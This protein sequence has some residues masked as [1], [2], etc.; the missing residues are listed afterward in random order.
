MKKQRRL[1]TLAACLV[2]LAV[3]LF[4]ARK[5]AVRLV[6]AVSVARLHIFT[7]PQLLPGESM[8]H[9]LWNECQ[10]YW[11]FAGIREAREERL[12]RFEPELKPLVGDIKRHQKAGEGMQHPCISTAKYAGG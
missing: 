5:S 7:P 8:A 11:D 1:L 6:T 10:F 9:R 12:K 3:A 4:A 2:P